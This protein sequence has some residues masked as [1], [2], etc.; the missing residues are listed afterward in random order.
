MKIAFVVDASFWLKEDQFNKFKDVYVVSFSIIENNS[1]TTYKTDYKSLT[2]DV[3]N[4]IIDNNLPAS[5]SQPSHYDIK[6]LFDR[7][8]NEKKYDKVIVLSMSKK[9]SGTHN[10]F[11]FTINEMG[12]N[13]DKFLLLNLS[14]FFLKAYFAFRSIYD[15]AIEKKASFKEIQDFYKN[16]NTLTTPICIACDFSRVKKS[17]RVFTTSILKKAASRFKVKLT[18][19]FPENKP[20][21]GAKLFLITRTYSKIIGKYKNYLKNDL[22]IDKI[23]HIVFYYSQLTPDEVS[24]FK[25]LFKEY[26]EAE[27][28]FV[29]MPP[30]FAAVFGKQFVIDVIYKKENLKYYDEFI[31]QK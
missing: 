15:L 6:K 12:K 4:H 23:Y 22:K 24:Y 21:A 10:A 5:S 20:G 2:W 16:W 19:L 3:I 7:L 29:K 31:Q 17:G 26:F 14:V 13:K 8:L 18:L 27:L 30:V 28:E 1:N 9:Y 11:N 25:K